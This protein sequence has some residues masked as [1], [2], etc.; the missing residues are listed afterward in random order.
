MESVQAD[1]ST[2]D[3]VG[4]LYKS[5]FS[6]HEHDVHR[7]FLSRLSR[8]NIEL[9][10]EASRILPKEDV[11]CAYLNA[12]NILDGYFK[13]ELTFYDGGPLPGDRADSDPEE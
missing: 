5:S 3:I 9:F 2:K 11:L 12:R 6:R 13:D 4:F 10:L 7:E 1:L 8:V